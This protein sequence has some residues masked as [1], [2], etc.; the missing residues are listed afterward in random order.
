MLLQSRF[1]SEEQSYYCK[2]I[3]KHSFVSTINS[4]ARDNAKWQ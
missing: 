4:L 1:Y 2:E 3:A